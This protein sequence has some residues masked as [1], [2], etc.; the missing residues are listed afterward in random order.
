M[1]KHK[2]LLISVL[3]PVDEPRMYEKMGKSLSKVDHIEVHIAGNSY[4]KQS[5]DEYIRF[6]PIF[7]FNRFSI[8]RIWAPF[9]IFIL[10]L[11]LKPSVVIATTHEVL[12]PAIIY[13]LLFWKKLIYDVQENYFK[14]IR[15]GSY[16][17]FLKIVLS[18]YIRLK[19]YLSHPLIN[20][21]FLAERC[22]LSEMQ[23]M[24]SK[25]TVLENKALPTTT[26]STGN[27]EL[28]LIYTGI[29]GETYGTLEAIQMAKNI[30]EVAKG[31]FKIVGYSPDKNYYHKVIMAIE[32]SPN[33]SL[34]GGNTFVDHDIIIE[35][36]S[37]SNLAIISY[38]NNAS[39]NNKVPTRIFEYLM[40][41]LPMIIPDNPNWI[42]YCKKYESA[43]T[44]NFS[45]P[46]IESILHQWKT[47][48]FYA[49]TSG[50][51]ISWHNEEVKLQ[52]TV[53]NI[54]I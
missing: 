39:I 20:H 21:Y 52:D 49:G 47:K 5:R 14:N 13:K 42:A 46:D 40:L 38:Q 41:K 10:L 53:V 27:Q 1:K 23:W 16:N 18:N 28:N 15:Y 37:K 29:I 11:R 50:P 8:Q 17:S 22:Y 9:K 2:V 48:S 51:E 44:A 54:L 4:S 25:G 26:A 45:N 6:H 31:T 34:I 43:I 3:K 30:L 35:E 12:M 24:R 33:V 7:S 32:N 19:E 36:A